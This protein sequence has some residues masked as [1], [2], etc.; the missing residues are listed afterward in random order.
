MFLF[1]IVIFNFINKVLDCLMNDIVEGK[2]YKLLF[3]QKVSV[4]MMWRWRS[5]V[6]SV[7]L[8]MTPYVLIDSK[9]QG[10]TFNIL[11]GTF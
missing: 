1:R 10:N 8:V 2:I 6:F 3:L 7:I 11:Q 4:K 9:K 5:G